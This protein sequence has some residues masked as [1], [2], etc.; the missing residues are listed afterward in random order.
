MEDMDFIGFKF[1]VGQ[2]VDF[3]PLYLHGVECIDCGRHAAP[4]RVGSVG[5]EPVPSRDPM[6]SIA[7]QEAF[8]G[9]KCC[10]CHGVLALACS[11][12]IAS[13]KLIEAAKRKFLRRERVRR[14]RRLHS[15]TVGDRVVVYKGRYAGCRG[16]VMSTSVDAIE[17]HCGMGLLYI[18]ACQVETCDKRIKHV[19]AEK[20]RR[21][22]RSV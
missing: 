15:F 18:A 4:V 20:M 5:W 16:R 8:Y 3:V 22:W 10:Y 21:K 7:D 17:I 6:S 1:K 2:F 13:S 11:S 9:L 12:D 14:L 19:F